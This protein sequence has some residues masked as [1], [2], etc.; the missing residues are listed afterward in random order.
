MKQ[1][2]SQE[3]YRAVQI[4]RRNHW[5]FRVVTESSYKDGWVYET[6]Q[7]I[8]DK[9]KAR[10]TALQ[11]AGVHFTEAIIAHEAPR[12]LSA[13]NDFKNT[14]QSIPTNKILEDLATGL[15]LFFALIFRFMLLDPALIVVLEDGTWL[16]VMTWYE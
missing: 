7:D 15:V 16:E 8:P 10:L 4:G 1:I 9:A 5:R 11:R 2:I 6:T 13:P 14:S 12:V 3:A